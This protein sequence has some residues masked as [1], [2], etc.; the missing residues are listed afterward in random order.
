[1]DHVTAFVNAE[2]IFDK[3]YAMFRSQG[4]EDTI[5][6]GLIVTAGIRLEF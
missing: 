3:E 4:R 6:P 2:N 1:V 5:A